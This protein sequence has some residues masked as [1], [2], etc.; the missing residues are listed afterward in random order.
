MSTQRRQSKP[1][2]TA[3]KGQVSGLLGAG[4]LDDAMGRL[5]N[6]FMAARILIAGVLVVVLL[7]LR[8]FGQLPSNLAFAVCLGYLALAVW[9]RVM[10]RPLRPSMGFDPQWLWTVGAD[11]G[12]FA[13]LLF[14]QIGILNFTPLFALPVLLASV[15]GPLLLALATAAAVTLVLL[16]DALQ[17]SGGF[18]T[19]EMA[20]RYSQAALSSAGLFAV[21]YLT[22]QLA[23]RLVRQEREALSSAMAARTQAQVNQ[24]VIDNL[25]DGVMVVDSRG[26]VRVANPASRAML[27]ARVGRDGASPQLPTPPFMLSSEAGWSPLVSL[28][29]DSFSRHNSQV[30]DVLIEQADGMQQRL[31]AYTQL[32]NP[33]HSK[34]AVTADLDEALCVVFLEDL[35]ALEARLRIEKL[36]AMGRMS[37]AVAHEIRNPLAAITQANALMAEESTSAAQQRLIDMVGQNAQR[38]ARIVDDVLDVSRAGRS[39]QHEGDESLSNGSHRLTQANSRMSSIC[40]D[41][42][43]QNKAHDRLL[44]R[45]QGPP[46]ELRFDEEHLRRVLV[47]LLDNALRYA[48]SQAGS[49]RVEYDLQVQ[50][51]RCL[52][53]VWSHAP[54]I[55]QGVQ[56]HLFEP[57][58]SSESR[59]SGLGLYICR[60]LCEQH[61]AQ[62]GYRRTHRLDAQQQAIEGN[63]FYVLI[64]RADASL[65]AELAERDSRFGWSPSQ[66]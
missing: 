39:A 65:A 55:E 42:A 46:F 41:W 32:A 30:R 27:G 18:G 35:R 47:N 21:A 20:T 11:V 29:N 33:Q 24:L 60:E 4:Q 48:S 54:A 23:T 17:S 40:N 8:M 9:T 3:D 2:R 43:I 19:A 28:V 12:V 10:A 5:W 61:G 25:S 66:L 37:A 1:R 13:V 58:F 44:V 57:F 52:L 34:G 62:I 6:G 36:A 64:D 26:V 49:I 15:L 51:G 7:M 53:L 56:Q 31:Q 14:S 63:E 22:N 16:A 59:S 45:L 38:L 50:P